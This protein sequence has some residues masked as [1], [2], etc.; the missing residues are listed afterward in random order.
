[1]PSEPIEQAIK[2][3]LVEASVAV[4]RLD[5]AK[6][7]SIA[8]AVLQ[9]DPENSDAQT[10]KSLASDRTGKVSDAQNIEHEIQDARRVRSGDSSS[11]S[12]R[13]QS[14]FLS[15][16]KLIV[17]A[18][19]IIV[20]VFF[21]NML[22]KDTTAEVCELITYYDSEPEMT[23]TEIIYF[24]IDVRNANENALGTIATPVADFFTGKYAGDNR[25]AEQKI[26]ELVSLCSQE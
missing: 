12:G 22:N 21:L 4:S 24:W 25:I 1:M 17:V 5:W 2:G 13:Q 14:R 7:I 19:V 15:K 3:L 16:K 9:L 20:G 11:S 10:F 23:T 26:D 8:D 18:L 6:V